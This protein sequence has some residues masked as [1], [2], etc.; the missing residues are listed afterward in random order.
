FEAM[1]KH[2]SVAIGPTETN[3]PWTSEGYFREASGP[4]GKL[5]RAKLGDVD[6]LALAKMTVATAGRL[7]PA[8][9]AEWND[10]FERFAK[11]YGLDPQQQRGALAALQDQREA[12]AVW[13]TA[14][15]PSVRWLLAGLWADFDRQPFKRTYPSG[16]IE[17]NLSV[18]ERADEYRGKLD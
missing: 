4:M 9:E 13:F 1:E 17:V 12:T 3:R 2:Y 11:H 8:L 16:V 14:R 7:P 10:Y 6:E 15:A 5:M 18:S